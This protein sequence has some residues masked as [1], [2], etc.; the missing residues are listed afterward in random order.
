MASVEAA[1]LQVQARQVFAAEVALAE[2]MQGTAVEQGL[3][4]GAAQGGAFM[5]GEGWG[6]AGLEERKTAITMPGF[7]VLFN[8]FLM[9][10]GAFL[11]R[12]LRLCPHFEQILDFAC[13]TRAKTLIVGQEYDSHYL[14]YKVEQK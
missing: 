5:D 6:H 12:F 4:V 9:R 7:G 14:S 11:I 2:F 13:R 10:F 1:A 8:T 3:E